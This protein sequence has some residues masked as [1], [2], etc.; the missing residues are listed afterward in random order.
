[1]LTLVNFRHISIVKVLRNFSAASEVNSVA[2]IFGFNNNIWR[3]PYFVEST[4]QGTELTNIKFYTKYFHFTDEV[5]VY[6]WKKRI[7]KQN[8][9]KVLVLQ[10]QVTE[11]KRL[12]EVLGSEN[13]WF[14][15]D[16]CRSFMIA[17]IANK[18]FSDRSDHMETKFSFF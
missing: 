4:G 8:I 2:Y 1:M 17:G 18:L 11:L 12:T 15:Y 9:L 10:W 14:P 3:L 6:C 13:G 5:S 16:H 7:S